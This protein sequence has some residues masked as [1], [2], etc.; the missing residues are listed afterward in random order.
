MKLR[1][2]R[3]IMRT[4]SALWTS[5]TPPPEVKTLL[6]EL[7]EQ[8]TSARHLFDQAEAAC[9][10]DRAICELTEGKGE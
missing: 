6:A 9:G 5:Y 7:D 8:K 3:A 2:V 1:E 4:L 10:T